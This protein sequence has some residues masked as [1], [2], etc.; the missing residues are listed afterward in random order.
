MN[1]LISER[2]VRKVFER[3]SMSKPCI[4]FFD[5]LDALVP[6]RNGDDS[7]AG[8]LFSIYELLMFVQLLHES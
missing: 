7:N 6:K 1:I 4:I 8:R 5:E 2:A 3:A